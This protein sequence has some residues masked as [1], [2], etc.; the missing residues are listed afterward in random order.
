MLSFSPTSMSSSLSSASAPMSSSCH[1]RL[2][3]CRRPCHQRRHQCRR[4]C[5]QRRQLVCRRPS[6]QQSFC[7]SPR[8]QPHFC[9]PFS[10]SLSA[11]PIHSPLS[12]VKV[13]GIIIFSLKKNTFILFCVRLYGIS[14]ASC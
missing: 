7:A 12:L 14:Y 9:H 3:Q 8:H 4:P 2:H 6:P 13:C 10:S 11:P 5:Q 1:H